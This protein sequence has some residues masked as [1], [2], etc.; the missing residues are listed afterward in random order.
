ML[1]TSQRSIQ[2]ILLRRLLAEHTVYSAR[3][4][5]FDVLGGNEEERNEGLLTVGL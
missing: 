3:A 5:S 2:P 4:V 1:S